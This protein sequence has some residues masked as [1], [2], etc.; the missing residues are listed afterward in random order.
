MVQVILSSAWV[1]MKESISR[2]MFR[3]CVIVNPILSGFLLGMMYQNKSVQD[4]MVYAF[5]GSGI[6]TFWSSIC[7][8]SASDID[9]EKWRGTLPVLFVA[10]VG[11]ECIILGKILGNT[12]WGLFSFFLNM[13]TVS[14]L[15]R[16]PLVF[17]RLDYF[18]LIFVLMLISMVCVAFMLA[19]LFTLSRKVR[20]LMNFI[21][22]PIVILTGMVFPISV[23]PTFVQYIA[24]VL[25]PTWIMKGFHLAVV[26][27]SIEEMVYVA[28]GLS[29]LTL[30]Y[31]LVS[32][33]VFKKI[34]IL[35][36]VHGT[37]EV[38]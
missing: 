23:F 2:S 36:L 30:V 14:V 10:P 33:V 16:M 38:F 5:I 25:S 11:F 3:F 15:F 32:R 27:G 18:I 12:L 28:V 21:D 8:S 20:V 19:G 34:K 31:M 7:F 6:Q 9:R 13:L 1:Q 22:Y 26:G 4:F 17:K 35:C 37:L 29:V 24:H